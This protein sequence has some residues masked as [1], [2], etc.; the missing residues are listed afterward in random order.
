[1]YKQTVALVFFLCKLTF[2]SRNLK[3]DDGVGNV[4]II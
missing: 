3:A 4:R 1:M 2:D